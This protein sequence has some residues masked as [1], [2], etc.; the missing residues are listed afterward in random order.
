MEY[1]LTLHKTHKEKK[2]AGGKRGNTT[3]KRQM[4]LRKMKSKHI[5]KLKSE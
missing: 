2:F 3:F 1:M 4:Q 5:D